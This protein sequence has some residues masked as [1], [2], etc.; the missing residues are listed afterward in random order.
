[1]SEPTA[2]PAGTP[3]PLPAKETK[4]AQTKPSAVRR[5][6]GKPAAKPAKPGVG[7]G[8]QIRAR[9][10][11]YFAAFAVIAFFFAGKSTVELLSATPVEI[12]VEGCGKGP[13]NK[14][15]DFG[16]SGT[17]HPSE[18]VTSHGRI[19]YRDD[20]AWGQ[21][22]K[23]W[24]IGREG[25][26]ELTGWY[27]DMGVGYSIGLLLAFLGVRRYRRYQRQAEANKGL[28][29]PRVRPL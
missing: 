29:G 2:R 11:K 24:A 16:C 14:Y 9:S 6:A 27:V 18:G 25:R 21:R 7:G 10:I 3:D 26:L 13:E 1:M 17:W 15:A 4:P 20:L 8:K 28:M 22:M 5:T 23:G 19:T 12:V